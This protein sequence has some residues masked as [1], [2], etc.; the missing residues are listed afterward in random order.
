MKIFMMNKVNKKL[1]FQHNISADKQILPECDD[2]E[3]IQTTT[4]CLHEL[5][6]AQVEQ[7]PNEVAVIFEN[8]KLTYRELN[9][10]ANQLANYLKNLGVGP[11]VLV[12][13][14][15]ERSLEMVVGLLAI[16][17]AG[18]AYVPLDP[19][20]PQERL[21]FILKDIQTPL[22][23]TVELLAK[24]LAIAQTQV[25]CLDS[26]WEIIAQNS[27]ENPVTE[28]TVNN[29][30][31]VI[32][33][34]GSTG[35]PKGVMITHRGICNTLC[36]RQN[37]FKLTPQDK[38]LQTISF[39]F[40]PSVWQI[41]WPLSFGAQLIMACPGGHQDPA[42]LIE[43]IIKQQ[44]TVIALVPSMMRLLLE[45]EGIENC[46]SLRHV[47]SGGEALPIELVERF[48]ARL[49]LDNIL[50]NCYGPTEAAIDA[51][52]WTCQRGTD[53]S[54]API[55][56]PITNTQIYILDE[57]L[58][59]V[60]VGEAGELHISSIGLAR[61]YLNRPE[62]TKQKFIP[63]PFAS[64][65]GTSLY[66]TGDLVR[67][68]PDGNIEFLGRIDNQVKISGFRIELGE[69]ETILEQHPAIKQTVVI[70]REDVPGDKRLVAYLVAK[71]QPSPTPTE[72]R[73]YLQQRF[74]EYMVP[75]AFVFVPQLPLT[76]NGKIDRRALPA[77]VNGNSAV[78]MV[79]PRNQVE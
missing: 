78:N 70:A 49:K 21:T 61:G 71:S 57:D 42:Y 38:V 47:T 55:G 16:L 65:V 50:Q 10:R 22:I 29:L 68:L 30:S 77:P 4:F 32:Y 15:L 13:I 17:K 11:E 3:T 75:S 25:V 19:A 51:T 28:V 56:R 23:L 27:R 1:E 66:K 14:C 67:Y 59:P 5:F 7:T 79:L 35:N 12:G 73:R 64:E 9:T 2:T 52:F 72:L 8:Q 76:P 45:E 74:P 62:L 41:F 31:Y 44:I 53:Y 40:D 48:F 36:W 20:Y 63:N 46:Q 34:S 37:T 54:F 24:N 33:T 26:D 18:G 43:T 60:A 39:S 6:T 58:Q 69:I